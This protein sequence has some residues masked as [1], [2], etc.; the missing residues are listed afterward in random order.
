MGTQRAGYFTTDGTKVPSV[1]TI[2]SRFKDAG[3]LIYWAW[4]QGKEGKDYRET[5]DKAATAG[6]LAH[7][8]VE[9]WIKGE[10]LVWDAPD[11]VTKRAR[12]AFEAFHEWSQQT[13]LKVTHTE[14]PL[15]SDKHKFGGTLDAMFIGSKRALG[16]WKTSNKIY[17]DYLMQLAAYGI[18][19]DEH[20]PNDPVTGG[21]HLLRFDGEYGDFHHHF[22]GELESAKR[23]FLLLREAFDLDK[24]LKKR[25]S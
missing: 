5:R 2:I 13:Q 12:I 9:R 6:T 14:V 4:Q 16:D 8:N 17:G 10:A 7:D 18:L 19:W 15:V 3:G 25:A 22:W 24:E 1:T 11:D 20:Y 21:Y 23:M